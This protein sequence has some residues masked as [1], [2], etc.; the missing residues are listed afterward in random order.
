[1]QGLLL[2]L[3]GVCTNVRGLVVVVEKRAR[4]KR[5]PPH[6]DFGPGTEITRRPC[7]RAGR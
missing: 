4:L 2:L 5:R 7:A 3:L 6:A 1:M